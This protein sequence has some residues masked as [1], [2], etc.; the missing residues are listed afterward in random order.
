MYFDH[1]TPFHFLP[2]PF[3][4]IPSQLHSCYLCPSLNT[5]KYLACWFSF[6]SFKA[7]L[8]NFSNIKVHLS[9]RRKIDVW[10]EKKNRERKKRRMDV[11]I[12]RCC[13]PLLAGLWSVEFFLFGQEIEIRKEEEFCNIDFDLNRSK[14]ASVDFLIIIFILFKLYC[15]CWPKKKSSI[16]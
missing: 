13:G 2:T 9:E 15:F 5:P 1:F 6:L 12:F 3:L 14:F 8:K 16:F 4:N 11:R 7:W 10:L